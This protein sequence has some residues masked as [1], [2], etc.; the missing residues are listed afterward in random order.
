MREAP[1]GHRSNGPRP[2][3]IDSRVPD[4]EPK[5]APLLAG[6]LSDR[7]APCESC[8]YNLRGVTTL[9]CPECGAVIPRPPH[10]E[11]ARIEGRKDNLLW[12]PKCRYPM[13]DLNTDRCPECGYQRATDRPPTR[14][15]GRFVPGVPT[16]LLIIAGIA[17]IELIPAVIK[18]ADVTGR[19][20]GSAALITFLALLAPTAFVGVFWIA[21]RRLARLTDA[22]F[23]LLATIATIVGLACVTSVAR[24][25]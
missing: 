15:R 19:W 18:A 8:G 17:L 14:R 12:C 10:E 2:L 9:F 25:F 3:P 16:L 11:V 4:P 13:H 1:G 20:A 24:L 7:D 21:R 23:W 22:A 6:F 5:A